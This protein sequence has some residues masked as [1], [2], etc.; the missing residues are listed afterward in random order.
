LISARVALSRP[1]VSG[2][3]PGDGHDAF[4]PSHNAFLN[5]F[6]RHWRAW[7]GEA[8]FD[9]MHFL[10]HLS[11]ETDWNRGGVGVYGAKKL[12]RELLPS[13][14]TPP[15][16]TFLARNNLQ[17][18]EAVKT[19]MRVHESCYSSGMHARLHGY[20]VGFT[21]RCLYRRLANIGHDLIPC[22]HLEFH[23]KTKPRPSSDAIITSTPCVG[24]LP[25]R[26]LVKT[27]AQ[28]IR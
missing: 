18:H 4:P 24:H 5:A 6:Q 7:R 20:A 16:S 9:E 19:M 22:P 25:R 1:Q 21:P 23:L 10:V 27:Y 17:N 12:L 26:N 28:L 13:L 8:F 14:F 3:S 2:G 11:P 15:P